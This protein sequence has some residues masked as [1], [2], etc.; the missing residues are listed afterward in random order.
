MEDRR[1][2]AYENLRVAVGVCLLE[3]V[4]DTGVVGEELIAV[5]GPVARVRVVETKVYDNNVRLPFECGLVF[6]QGGVRTVSLVQEGSTRVAEVTHLVIVA[7][8]LLQLC[9]VRSLCRVLV[10]VSVC[11]TVAHAGNLFLFLCHCQQ[12]QRKY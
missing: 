6:R 3:T 8:Q 1:H 9:G 7:Q 12:R 10:P 2:A 5:V 11:D 4:N